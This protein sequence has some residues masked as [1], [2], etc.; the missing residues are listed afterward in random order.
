MPGTQRA[1]PDNQRFPALSR[2]VPACS[3]LA[4]RGVCE[5]R[6][7]QRNGQGDRRFR[8]VHVMEGVHHDEVMVPC[9]YRQ[10]SSASPKRRDF[11][12]YPECGDHAQLRLLTMKS[13]SCQ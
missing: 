6:V 1:T 4:L 2:R 3:E 12:V 13:R 9:Y 10:D 5:G 7:Q 8:A 11:Q